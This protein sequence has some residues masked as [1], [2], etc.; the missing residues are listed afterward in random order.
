MVSENQSKTFI[1]INSIYNVVLSRAEIE[2][3]PNTKTSLI[4]ES[5]SVSLSFEQLTHYAAINAIKFAEGEKKMKKQYM[6]NHMTLHRF[7]RLFSGEIFV[8]KNQGIFSS[9][10]DISFIF[11]SFFLFLLDFGSPGVVVFIITIIIVVVIIFCSLFRY[12]CVLL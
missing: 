12:F 2:D 7:I 11:P 8:R 5:Q 9:L 3:E 1:L 6:H 10:P 4:S